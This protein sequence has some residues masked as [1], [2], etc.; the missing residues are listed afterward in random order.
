M[1][2]ITSSAATTDYLNLLTIQLQNQDPI[3]PINQEDFTA[4]LAQFSML[5]QMENMNTTFEEVLRVEQLNQGI[6][7]IGKQA[8]YV[9]PLT[10]EQSSGLVE[11]LYADGNSANLL[12]NGQRVD[13]ANV[14]GVQSTV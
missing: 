5:E 1:T 14:S 7:L 12:I 2:A 4:Q 6:N 3:E 11:E 10:G 8:D 9:D 13:L